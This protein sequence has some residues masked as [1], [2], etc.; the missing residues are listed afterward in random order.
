[1]DDDGQQRRTPF[2]GS[3]GAGVRIAVIDSGVHPDHPHIR[4]DR[5][6]PGIAILP[7]GTTDEGSEDRLGHGTAVMAAIQE[8]APDALCLPVRVFHDALRTSATGLIAAID[9]SVAQGVDIINLSLGSTNAAHAVAFAD[10][11]GRATQAG[12]VLVAAA[13]DAEGAPCYPG[14]LPDVLGV[15]VDWHCP[16]GRYHWSQTEGQGGILRFH[17]SGYPRPIPGVPQRRNLYG[18]SFA[19][20]Q[21]TGFAARAMG[22]L[23]AKVDASRN[24]LV[25]HAMMQATA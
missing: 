25:R 12:V 9:W 24:G 3:T 6:H 15:E 17:A 8:K 11:A 1:M 7:N 21:M 18:V 14:S 2:A 10:A 13:C 5:L 20:A 19:V 4:A 23:D 22:T 16:R